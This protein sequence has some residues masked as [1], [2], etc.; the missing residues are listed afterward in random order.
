MNRFPTPTPSRRGFL[1]AAAST[2][3]VAVAKPASSHTLAA[4]E[5]LALAL[6]AGGKSSSRRHG[7]YAVYVGVV[8]AGFT[9]QLPVDQPADYQAVRQIKPRLTLKAATGLCQ[10]FNGLQLH[11]GLPGRLWG[12]VM[13]RNRLQT[14][15]G[16]AANG[17]YRQQNGAGRAWSVEE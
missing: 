7:N 11:R 13:A 12:F 4:G 14:R 5:P 17:D 2:A 1:A 9:P 3:L 16:H 6:D 8:P 15:N 10:R